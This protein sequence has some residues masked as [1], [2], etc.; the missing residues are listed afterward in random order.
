MI[1]FDHNSTTPMHNSVRLELLQML[2]KPFNPS[3][4]HAHGRKAK[5]YLEKARAQVKHLV[6]ADTEY[7][8]IFTSSG[9][10]ANNIVI[11]GFGEM[12][13][14]VSSIEHH[15]V[16]APAGQGIIG[17]DKNGVVRLDELEQILHQLGKPALVSIM[18]ANNEIGVLQPVK[19]AARIVHKYNG[20]IHTDA[21]QAAGKI[22]VDIKELDVDMLT[23]SGHKIGGMTGAG[24]LIFRK[25]LMPVPLMLG[26]G[27]EYSLRPGTQNV[28]AIYAFGLAAEIVGG[29]L[30]EF[31]KY[32]T[33]RD[34][35]EES[36]CSISPNTIIFGKEVPRLPNTSSITMPNVNNETQIMHFD[37]HGISVSAGAACSS[38]KVGFPHVQM[39]MGYPEH[40]A[41]QA[42]RISMGRGNIKESV[43][44]FITTWQKLYNRTECAA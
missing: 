8:L 38:G 1:Y 9:T 34:Y 33:F 32:A 37:L 39:S 26:G 25:G 24:A 20:I 6:N 14:A 31:Q 21:T 16:L 28:T 30:M 29:Q 18:L 12:P 10:E 13:V 19:E 36:I 43:D 41:R 35:L 23:M 42:I 44:A 4:V 3:S 17:V 15:S 7:Q 11:R 22:A 5:V 40:I 2:G 27:Q